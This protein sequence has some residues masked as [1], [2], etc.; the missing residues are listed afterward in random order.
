MQPDAV[1]RLFDEWAARLARGERPDP[2]EYLVEAGKQADELARMMQ[3]FLVAAPRPEPAEESIEAMRAWAAS[4]SPLVALRVRRGLRRDDLVD[5]VITEFK[6]PT[7]KRPVVKRYIHRL[8]AGLID[9]RRLSSP[10]LALLETTLQTSARTILGARVRPLEATPAFREAAAGPL[11]APSKS[12]EQVEED[13]Q[14]AEL[15]LSGR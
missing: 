2:E 7:E 8:E 6:L 9:P 14:I 12:S 10:L 13:P 5:A 11:A 4:E 3:A 15:F 1:S